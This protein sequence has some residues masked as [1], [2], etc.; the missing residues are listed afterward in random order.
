M[1]IP[2][3]L[4]M[5]AAEFQNSPN[6]PS[7]FA[8]MACHFSPYGTGLTNL[9]TQ[10]PDGSILLINDRTPIHGHD[11]K[12]V[13]ETV[14]TVLERN[15][16]RGIA[17]DFQHDPTE[18][19]LSICRALEDLPCPVYVPP[20]YLRHNEQPVFLPPPC[21]LQTVEDYLAEYQNRPI[22]L[23]VALDAGFLRIQTQGQDYF[24]RGSDAGSPYPHADEALAIH[25]R[26][27]TTPDS[28]C[29]Y[30][31]RTLTNVAQIQHR[32]QDRFDCLFIGLWQEFKANN[33]EQPN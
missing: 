27:E 32:C 26:I 2:C 28:A 25:Y 16:C 23:E 15:P 31:R 12:E 20:Q 17:L 7:N 24:P 8:W 19:A 21:P 9:P 13:R 3:Y 6:I 1:E 14:M 29:F 10:I 11:G 5:T 30:F 18:E 33:A 4:A 22:L